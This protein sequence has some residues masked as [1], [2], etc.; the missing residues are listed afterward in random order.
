MDR[1]KDYFMVAMIFFVIRCTIETATSSF[2]TYGTNGLMGR[3][4]KMGLMGCLML[5]C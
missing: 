1:E 4:G 2:F 5:D 3:M